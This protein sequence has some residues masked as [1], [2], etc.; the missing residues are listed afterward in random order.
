[1]RWKWGG[2]TMRKLSELYEL[3]LKLIESRRVVFICSAIIELDAIGDLSNDEFEH[4]MTDFH[5]TRNIA[6]REFKAR[7]LTICWWTQFDCESRIAFLKH[8]IKLYKEQDI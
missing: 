7:E 8:L 1:M 5:S 6:V 2:G 4:L 3:V